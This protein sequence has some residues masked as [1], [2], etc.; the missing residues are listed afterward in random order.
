MK[1][2]VDIDSSTFDHHSYIFL[3]FKFEQESER[4]RRLTIMYKKEDYSNGMYE[5]E[6]GMTVLVRPLDLTRLNLVWGESDLTCTSQG[7]FGL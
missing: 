7:G 5:I 2:H 1:G 6:I 4:M 3:I